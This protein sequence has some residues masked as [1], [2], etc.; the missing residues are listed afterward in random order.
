[1][2]KPTSKVS[3]TKAGKELS[4]EELLRKEALSKKFYNLKPN[5]VMAISSALVDVKVRK[6]VNEGKTTLQLIS[7]NKNG[8]TL[9][10][11]ARLFMDEKKLPDQPYS[12]IRKDDFITKSEIHLDPS[13]TSVALM[14]N[15]SSERKCDVKGLQGLKRGQ[16]FAGCLVTLPDL[17]VKLSPNMIESKFNNFTDTTSWGVVR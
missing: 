3:I 17:I 2:G 1:M 12:V 5:E 16:M 4:E 15:F 13:V 6:V 9:T 8:Y 11:A 7:L 14:A 10:V